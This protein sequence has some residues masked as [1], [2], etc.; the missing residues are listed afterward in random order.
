M[1]YAAP[2]PCNQPRCNAHSKKGGRCDEHQPEAWV[3]SKG[4]TAHER[5]YGYK[6]TKLRNSILKRDKYLCKE[7][8]KKGVL[9][10]AKEVDHI[11]N[12]AQGGTDSVVNLQSLCKACHKTKTILERALAKQSK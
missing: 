11:L 10:Q 3:S 9:T 7:C 6:W 5:G 4:K 12:K 8:L 1:P 2:K